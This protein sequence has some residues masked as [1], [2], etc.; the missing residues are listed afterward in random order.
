MGSSLYNGI[1]NR[2]VIS[3]SGTR[4]MGIETMPPLITRG[5]LIDV[6]EFEQVDHL[7]AG[8]AIQPAELDETL[9][10]QKSEVR[11]GDPVPLRTG[12]G[13]LWKIPENFLFGEPGLGKAC[14]K[15]AVEHEIVCWGCDQFAT[16]PIPFETEGEVLPMHPE[17]L[18]KAGIRLVEKSIWRRSRDRKYTS[19]VFSR[20]H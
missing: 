20:L 6:A 13:R 4:R 17:M 16:D 3:T 7:E 5:V 14:A 18:T 9:A 2:D 1:K 8:Y 19:F 11:P 10:A 15:W 12:W